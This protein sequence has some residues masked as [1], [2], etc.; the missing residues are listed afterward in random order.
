MPIFQ[1]DGAV[2]GAVARVFDGYGTALHAIQTVYDDDGSV[3]TLVFSGEV[4]V[5]MNG[6]V[7]TEFVAEGLTHKVTGGA[8]VTFNADNIHLKTF[9]NA[10]TNT[11][12]RAYVWTAG[13]V[14][15]T[16]FSTVCV[17][18]STHEAVSAGFGKLYV[19]L[20]PSIFSSQNGQSSTIPVAKVA[21]TEDGVARLEIADFQGEY[22]VGVMGMPSGS[23]NTW[24]NAKV[25]K[26][27]LE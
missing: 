1:Y 14:D 23:W 13:K 11:W 20:S 27:W 21:I 12:A 19:F 25:T 3:K 17:Q 26:I 7:N 9:N 22:Y 5:Y 18:A 8:T 10:S 2:S 6:I 4:P 16:G 15:T 24:G